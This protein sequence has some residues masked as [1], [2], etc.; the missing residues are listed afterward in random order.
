MLIEALCKSSRDNEKEYEKLKQVQEDVKK[1]LT[2][3]DDRVAIMEKRNRLLQIYSRIDP[4]SKSSYKKNE[5]RKS[6][7]IEAQRELK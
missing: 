1:I 2:N 7:L 4:K 3:V 6:D 5:F